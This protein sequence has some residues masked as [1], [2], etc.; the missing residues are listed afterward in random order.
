MTENTDLNRHAT[1]SP[2]QQALAIIRHLEK[3]LATV[4]SREPEA[5]AVIGMGCRFPG[6]ATNPELY[7]QLLCNGFDAVGPIP[8]ERWAVNEFY[9]PER[10]APGK[11]YTRSAS[12]LGD[13]TGFDAGFFGISQEEACSLDPQQRLCLE[14]IWEAL[15][16]AAIPPHS[17]KESQ[18]AVFI[19]I[20]QNDYGLRQ[21]YAG[22]LERINRYDAS[23]NAFCFAPGRI[24]HTLGLRGPSIAVDCAGAG[25]LVAIHLACQSLRARECDLALAGGVQLILDPAITVFLCRLGALSPDGRCKAF[26]D[27]ADGFGRGEGCGVV[28]LKR[29]SDAVADGDFIWATIPGSVVNHDGPSTGLTAPSASAQIGLLAR[30]LAVAGLESRSVGYIETHGT[31][32]LLGD[33]IE[34]EALA[35]VYGP[36]RTRANPLWLGSGKTN[37]GHME[38]AAGVAGFIKAVLSLH[39]GKLPPHL[40]LRSPSSRIPWDAMPFRLPTELVDWPSDNGRIAGVSSFGLAGT[41]AHVLLEAG[42]THTRVPKS[43]SGKLLPLVLSARSQ[44]ALLELATRFAS[45][46][47]QH[48]ELDAADVCRTAALGR[49]HFEHRVALVAESREDF[50][51]RLRAVAKGEALSGTWV[52]PKPYGQSAATARS[53]GSAL[54]KQMGD[55]VVG[56]PVGWKDLFPVVEGNYPVVLPTYPFERRRYWIESPEELPLELTESVSNQV[57]ADEAENLYQIVWQQTGEGVAQ[58]LPYHRGL[59]MVLC[60]ADGVG[61]LIAKGLRS[62]EQRCVCVWLGPATARQGPDDWVVSLEDTG[63]LD[64]L[65]RSLSAQGVTGIVHCWSVGSL[66]ITSATDFRAVR[67]ASCVSALRLFQ[68]LRRLSPQRLPRI[69]LV[70][71][72]CQSVA[73]GLV[74]SGLAQS[75]VWGF[76]RCIALEYPELWGGLHDLAPNSELGDIEGIIQ[77]LLH[78]SREQVVWRQGRAWVPTLRRA[79]TSQHQSETL[80]LRS[81]GTYWVTGGWGALGLQ[82][83]SCLADHGAGT[84]VLSARSEPTADARAFARRCQER[85]L[86]VWLFRSDC[87]DLSATAEI[88]RQIDAAAK[89]LC[90]VFHAAGIAEYVDSDKLTV[91]EFERVGRAKIE[92]A[93]NLHQAT[94]GHDLDHFILF[95]SISSVWGAKGLAPYAA[96]NHFMDTLAS[97]RRTIGLPAISINWGPWSGGGLVPP[98]AGRQLEEIGIFSLKPQVALKT[99]T[100]LMSFAAA[101]QVVVADIDWGRFAPRFTALSR[102]S[103]FRDL[104]APVTALDVEIRFPDAREVA[105][106]E[107]T[108]IHK[109]GETGDGKSEKEPAPAFTDQPNGQSRSPSKK[110]GDASDESIAVVGVGVR[111]PG[112]ANSLQSFWQLLLNKYDAVGPVPASRWDLGEYYDPDVSK[113]GR[114]YSQTGAFL[115]QIEEFDAEFFRISP[116][117]ALSLDP[118]QRLLLEVTWEALENAGIPPSTLAETSTGVFVGISNNDYAQRLVGDAFSHIDSHFVTGNSLNA[119]AGRISYI[120]G[121]QG[122]SLAIDTACSSSLVAIHLACQSLRAGECE[123]ALAGGVNLTLSPATWIAAC[124]ARMLAPDGRCKTFDASADGFGRGEGCAMVVLKRLSDALKNGDTV[125]G[126]IRG[127]AVNQDGA[128][129][130]FTVPNVLAQQKLIAR[131][132]NAARVRANQISYLETHGTGTSLGDPIEYRAAVTS[133]GKDRTRPLILGAVKA[134]IGHLESAAGIA[135]LVKAMLVLQHRTVPPQLHFS[136]PNPYIPW[137]ELPAIVPRL[138][139]SLDEADRFAAASSFGVSG[140]NAHVILEA[141][142]QPPVRL[143]SVGKQPQFVLAFSAKAAAALLDLARAYAGLAES[144]PNVEVVDI[145]FSA[146]V[147]RDHFANRAAVIAADWGELETKLKAFIDGTTIP[148]VFHGVVRSGTGSLQSQSATANP[149]DSDDTTLWDNYLSEAA[150]RYVAGGAAPLPLNLDH[151]IRVRLPNYPWQRTRFWP[152]NDR[153]VTPLAGGPVKSE[154]AVAQDQ[155]EDWFYQVDWKVRPFSGTNRLCHEFPS[156]AAIEDRL[157]TQITR[158]EQNP[159]TIAFCRLAQTLERAS[160]GYLVEAFESLGWRW[161]KGERYTLDEFIKFSGVRTGYRRWLTRLFQILE[162]DGLVSRAGEAWQVNSLMEVDLARRFLAAT[163]SDRADSIEGQLL[164]RCGAKLAA[165]LRGEC[166]PLKLLFPGDGSVSAADLYADS[167]QA[168]LLN[169]L[170]SDTLQQILATLSPYHQLKVLEVGA[171][172]GGTTREILS[173]FPGEQTRYVMSDV[174][175][176]FVHRASDHFG[177]HEFVDFSVLDIECLPEPQ[178]FELATYDL[179]VAANVLHATRDI[180]ACLVHIRQLLKPGGLLVLL[181]GTGPVRFID[182]IFGSTDGWWRFQDPPLRHDYPLIGVDAWKRV[183]GANGFSQSTALHS[184]EDGNGLLAKRAILIARADAESDICVQAEPRKWLLFADRGGIADKVRRSLASERDQV[185]TVRTQQNGESNG[186]GQNYRQI[187]LR[188][189]ASEEIQQCLK[190]LPLDSFAGVIHFWGCD[191]DIKESSSPIEVAEACEIGTRTTLAL[192]QGVLASGTSI[193]PPT[194]IVTRGVAP[195]LPEIAGLPQSP[196]WGMLKCAALE[197]PGWKCARID[198]PL[199]PTES[200]LEAL[201]NE[202]SSAEPEREIVLREKRWVARLGRTPVPA[203]GFDRLPAEATYLITGGSRGLGP[204]V[205]L[206]MAQRGAKNVV[207]ISRTE[208]DSDAKRVFEEAR[209]LGCRT[210][211]LRADVSRENELQAVLATIRSTMPAL[212]GVIHAAGVLDDGLIVHQN[213]D[214]FRQVFRAKIDGAWALHRLTQDTPLDFFVMF[215]SM[216]SLFGSAGQSNHGAANGFLDALAYYRRRRGL[217]AI[218]I[219]W[220]PWSEIGAAARRNVTDRISSKGIRVI[221][222]EAGLSALE[223]CLS[224]STAQVGIGPIDW[225]VFLRQSSPDQR[226]TWLADFV[227]F[228]AEP[229]PPPEQVPVEALPQKLRKQIGEADDRTRPG[230]LCQYVE[231]QVREVLRADTQTDLS[232]RQPLLELGLDSLMGTELNNRF[233]SELGVAVPMQIM[234]GSGTISDLAL[235]LADRLA[236]SK[237]MSAESLDTVAPAEMEDITI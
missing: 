144:R 100:R 64:G 97:W 112:K 17:L 49:D 130:G 173:L 199:D 147:Y 151:S 103:F 215:S 125:D 63:A 92:G 157:A 117:E 163:V 187:V 78:P 171:G 68:A 161:Q 160:T 101:P 226:E 60:D 43:G 191:A 154:N 180:A 34:A 170:V 55:Y 1:L 109:P 74:E 96:A 184:A 121:L 38:S 79:E 86:D 194:Y 221:S 4:R 219:N 37:H 235:H 146:A 119:A 27:A 3:E 22:E 77:E 99:L 192:L 210:T 224:L 234:I 204:A 45:Y 223:R 24:S 201:V 152:D 129:S 111:L 228:N 193:R 148:G 11:I 13:V 120:L 118:Q 209:T 189:Q 196:V 190:N 135:G 35:A 116:R 162:E 126:V 81:D 46:W 88:V 90:G 108:T 36:K 186:D 141:A 9:D 153:Q 222:K 233:I 47:E 133:Y 54:E 207:L 66:P 28:A 56:L 195:T 167:V 225:S 76:A 115:D 12:L 139:L 134:N 104:D 25:S 175:P 214:R 211:W 177:K 18:T 33:S 113:P 138:P 89:R 105:P 102:H 181:E 59:W 29:L 231:T 15:E 5:I 172:T 131:A 69:W 232:L 122:P 95:S 61:E 166:E 75:M 50:C 83:A 136:T 200:V 218:S 62:R 202:F 150:R 149:P 93:W 123:V 67:Q 58:D 6:G 7:W 84:I 182:L 21:L 82:L 57:S 220:G 44:P 53:T 41:N 156:P 124:R 51:R 237:T 203:P 174:A 179:V 42:P 159:E 26:D 114:I 110:F 185:I 98:E 178:G 217:P 227:Q 32:S 137:D 80:T 30:A 39:H 23:G 8:E 40:H 72:G 145:C 143:R 31:G 20:G 216:A 48:P 94:R 164:Q 158:L 188:S 183:L 176:L 132:L 10:T 205:G 70:T 229:A 230:L 213:W 165:T 73:N 140:T 87:G 19:G 236:V 198:L 14:V 106:I 142:P 155:I 52:G 169:G 2:L 168:K 128:S 206:R 107:A 127:S 85:G 16:H 212:R 65:L 197:S 91:S 71:Q 208:P